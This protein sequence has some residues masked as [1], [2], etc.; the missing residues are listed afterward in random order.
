MRDNWKVNGCIAAVAAVAWVVSFKLQ[1]LFLPSLAAA[2]GIDLIFIPSGVRLLVILVGGVWA[3]AGVCIGTLFLAGPEF[4]TGSPWIVAAVALCSGLCPYLAIRLSLRVMGVDSGLRT[5]APLHMPFLSLGVAA[6]SA[7]LHNLLFAILGVAPWP[8][9]A[10]H[11]LSM[12]MG[13]FAGSLI[14]VVAA[15][16]CLRVYRRRA[17]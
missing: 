17:A 13:D 4:Q 10:S 11:T 12:A 7:L 8:A 6:G 1:D 3:A 16:W 14:A 5:L 15:Y 2:P 9:F